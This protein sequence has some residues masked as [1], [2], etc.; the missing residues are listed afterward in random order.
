MKGVNIMNTAKEYLHKLIDEIGIEEVP[1]IIDFVE[2]LKNNRGEI[3]L[4][5]VPFT[6][7]KSSIK[8]PVVILSNND[9][10]SGSD[11]LI[12]YFTVAEPLI[13]S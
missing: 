2:Y 7:L 11:D 6:D 8:R 13:R 3:V 12:E 10:N 1:E 5:P 9:Y 4:I